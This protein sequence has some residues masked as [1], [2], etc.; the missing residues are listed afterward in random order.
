[1]K[2]IVLAV[3]LTCV[4]SISFAEKDLNSI[5]SKAM[6]DQG[7][8][9][10]SK[11]EVKRLTPAAVE[12]GFAPVDNSYALAS[13]AVSAPSLN[14]LGRVVAIGT[15]CPN[16]A[17]SR[18]STGKMV[19]CINSVWALPPSAEKENF[20]NVKVVLRTVRNA[21]MCETRGCARGNLSSFESQ[22]SRIK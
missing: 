18:E 17:I 14:Q 2:R 7:A 12:G 11:A 4:S 21:S 22:M 20:D 9:S 19:S 1:M 10:A 15:S 5:F 13:Q 3:S 8:L 6:P 16:G